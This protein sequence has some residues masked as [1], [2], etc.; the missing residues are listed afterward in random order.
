VSDPVITISVEVAAI[1]GLGVSLL[2]TV[3][4]L[5]SNYVIAR[6]TSN[7]P[8]KNELIREEI[9]NLK[10]IIAFLAELKS[11]G[12]EGVLQRKFL[13]PMYSNPMQVNE[14]HIVCKT[15]VEILAEMRVVL[16]QHGDLLPTSAQK[17]LARMLNKPNPSKDEANQLI[18]EM[19]AS[20]DM[21][22]RKLRRK[23]GV[24]L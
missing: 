20:F 5:G 11:F 21:T 12:N 23:I 2:T 14:T 3:L 24:Y 16:S 1:L 4:T 17:R 13:G 22:I 9:T 10:K 6:L 7:A 19:L 18:D 8:K 15:P